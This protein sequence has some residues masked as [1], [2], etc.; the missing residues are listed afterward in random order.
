LHR[1]R[2][3]GLAAS[4]VERFRKQVRFVQQLGR[5]AHS[6]YL[7]GRRAARLAQL[8]APSPPP[9]TRR[10]AAPR[11]WLVRCS[12]MVQICRHVWPPFCC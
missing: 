9:R 6:R 7:P 2:L 3:A 4:S 12:W 11:E 10:S 5:I 8:N 1:A